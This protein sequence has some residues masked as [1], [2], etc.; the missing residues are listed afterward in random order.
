MQR[1]LVLGPSGAGKSRLARQIAEITGLPLV[2]LDQ[3]YWRP[4]WREPDRE[5]WAAQVAEL[6]AAPRWVM[7]GNFGGTLPQRLAA[8]DTAI[9]LDMPTW[10]CLLRVLRRIIASYGRTRADL[11]PGCP[12]RFDIEFLIYVCLY[13]RRDQPRHMRDVA[14]FG[15]RLIRLR[16]RTEVGAFISGL[17]R[18]KD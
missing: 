11:A 14:S 15:G 18:N 1:V 9:V 10:L 6:I 16:G 3:H 17:T 4:G 13:R 5:I 8:A 7:D 12:E 2:H